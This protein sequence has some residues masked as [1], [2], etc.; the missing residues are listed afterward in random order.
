MK[1]GLVLGTEIELIVG[2]AGVDAA[3]DQA[4]RLAHL[5]AGGEDRRISKAIESLRENF[6]RRIA[7]GMLL[8][9]LGGLALAW[10]PGD[11]PLSTGSLLVAAACFCWAVDNNLTRK[12]SLHDA[13]WI[14]S[15][16]TANGVSPASICGR[17]SY[18]AGR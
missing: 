4:A 11:V 3:A 14:A 9:V 7:V 18:Q 12:V 2:A 5:F 16:T 17:Y 15:V 8:I 1:F 13:A 10:A 6:D